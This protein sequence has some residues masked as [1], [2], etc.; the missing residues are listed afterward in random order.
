MNE[1]AKNALA[2]LLGRA[3]RRQQALVLHAQRLPERRYGKRGLYNEFLKPELDAHR[4]VMEMVGTSLDD[5]RA[6]V[7]QMG[8]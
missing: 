6:M 5:L 8:D 4:K 2:Q 7:A 1:I 3:G